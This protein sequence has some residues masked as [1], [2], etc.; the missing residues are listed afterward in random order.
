MKNIIVNVSFLCIICLLFGCNEK[1]GEPQPVAI[2]KEQIKKEI[3]AKEDTFAAHYNRGDVK[4]IG[5]YADDA[6]SFFQNRPPLVGKEAII[7]FLKADLI[8]NSDSIAF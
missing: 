6:T 8:S 1:K 3:Q 5:Y 7:D 4:N 2:D